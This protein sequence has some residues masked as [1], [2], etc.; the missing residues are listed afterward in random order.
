LKVSHF[1][2]GEVAIR[3]ES[4]KELIVVFKKILSEDEY[5][6]WERGYHYQVNKASKE[7]ILIPETI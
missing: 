4:N 5:E 3:N 1:F 7:C 2:F 6:S